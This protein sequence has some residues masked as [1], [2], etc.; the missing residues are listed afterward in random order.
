MPED[1][2]DDMNA[3]EAHPAGKGPVDPVEY[4]VE[5]EPDPRDMTREESQKL[6][7]LEH[8]ATNLRTARSQLA[9]FKV[10]LRLERSGVKVQISDAQGRGLN[11]LEAITEAEKQVEALVA[12]VA[13]AEA[14]E[15]GLPLPPK[16]MVPDAKVPEGFEGGKQL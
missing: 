13:E 1:G 11:V 16:L 12:M 9:A 5:P 6:F 7:D 4:G 15:T 3:R 10:A 2:Q 14:S 8:I